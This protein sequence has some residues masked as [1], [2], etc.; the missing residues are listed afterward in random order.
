LARLTELPYFGVEQEHFVFHPGKRPPSHRTTE[1]LWDLLIANSGFSP[2]STTSSGMRLSIERDSQYGPIV[3]SNDSCTHIIEV[4]FPKMDSIDAFAELYQTTWQTLEEHLRELELEIYLGSSIDDCWPQNSAFVKDENCS[5][6]ID[7]DDVSV[8]NWRPKESEP[9]G[10]RLKK[11]L[12]RQRLEDPLFTQ[13]FPAC[14][15][16]TH[17]NFDL[18]AEEVIRRLPGLYA[19]E[20]DV[21]KRFTQCKVFRGVKGQCVRLLAWLANY[22]RPYPM[23]GIPDRLPISLAE[24]NELCSQCDGRDYSFVSIRD[25]RRVEFRSAC[26]QPTVYDVLELIRFRWNRTKRRWMSLRWIGTPFKPGLSMLVGCS[27]KQL[28]NYVIRQPENPLSLAIRIVAWN[29]EFLQ[30]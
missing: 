30:A 14:F 1:L 26:S 11:F 28:I 5:N 13:S 22:H 18:D 12:Q 10:T 9:E 3:I 19:H 2:R 25:A 16:S 8:I 21:P 27:L 7:L 29:D 24:Y 15:T 6:T 17:I 4:A 23:L 20:V